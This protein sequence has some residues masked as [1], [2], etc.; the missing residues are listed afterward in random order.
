VQLRFPVW[1]SKSGFNG[2]AR[3]A[4]PALRSLALPHSI[5]W[6]FSCYK[7]TRQ[8]LW[9]AWEAQREH[10][11]AR[12]AVV[13]WAVPGPP[14]PPSQPPAYEAPPCSCRS[15]TPWPSHG[16]VSMGD[17]VS[18][19]QTR[20]PGHAWLTAFCARTLVGATTEVARLRNDSQTTQIDTPGPVCSHCI[21]SPPPCFTWPVPPC[22]FVGCERRR[23]GGSRPCKARVGVGQGRP[24]AS[25]SNNRGRH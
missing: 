1:F 18:P 17:D 8:T 6:S 11:L 21:A 19:W 13:P 10:P 20:G 14:S 23:V 3:R 2:L 25:T 15:T 22:F 16:R 24:Q 4:S 9:P 7:F 12:G 5:T